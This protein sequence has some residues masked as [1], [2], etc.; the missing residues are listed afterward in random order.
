MR[1]LVTGASGAVGPV[2]VD[3]LVACGHQVTVYSRQPD[4]LQWPPGV[5]TAAGDLLDSTQLLA[6]MA[7]S[8]VVFH[9]AA[10]LH[11]PNPTTALG[12]EYQRVNVDGTRAVME[13]ARFTTVRRVVF[14]STI[15]VYGLTGGRVVDE[16]TTPMPDTMYARTKL[17]AEAIVLGARDRDGKALGTVLRSAAVYGGRVKG[18][19]NHLVR[20][21]ARGRFIPIG[22]G[23]NRRTV[24]FDEDL[25]E[26][27]I[28][29]T[30]DAAAGRMFNV[31]DGRFHRLSEIIAAI[32]QG[33]GRRPPHFHIPAAPVRLFASVADIALRTARVPR[34]LRPPLDT[35]LS[36]VAVDATRIQDDLAWL[37]RSDLHTGWKR[38]ISTMRDI[39]SL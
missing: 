34:R 13:M 35:Y 30:A 4:R 25:A 22:A 5:A 33:L 21:L 29:A 15:A 20:A 31:S 6:A 10:L 11:V 18:N 9:L 8:E 38:A 7:G 17:A 16:T 28:A 26:A 12:S 1:C 32:A 14:F 27:A 3:R 36:D 39:G 24:I 23:R 37:P 19:Y 2:L